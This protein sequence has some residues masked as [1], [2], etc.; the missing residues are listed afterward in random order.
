MTDAFLDFVGPGARL[1]ALQ[2]GRAEDAV[3]DAAAE[4][5]NAAAEVAKAQAWASSLGI[6]DPAT[7]T[8]KSARGYAID[9]QAIL[10]EIEEGSDPLVAAQV[11]AAAVSAAVALVAAGP[12]YASTA[13][14]LAATDEGDAFAVFDGI[15]TVT[16]YRHDAGPVATALRSFPFDLV[17]RL[18]DQEQ[19]IASI[20]SPTVAALRLGR[21]STAGNADVQAKV[22]SFQQ[23]IVHSPSVSERWRGVVRANGLHFH[24]PYDAT[25]VLVH[26]PDTGE[27]WQTNFGLDLSGT[28]KWR[29]A[30][31]A[32]NG[33]I[34]CVPYTSQSVLVIDPVAMTATLDVMGLPASALSGTAKWDGG[35]LANDGRIYCAPFQSTTLL[36]IDPANNTAQTFTA[37]QLGMGSTVLNGGTKYSGM[38]AVGGFVYATPFTAANVLRVNIATMVATQETYSLT[39]SDNNKWSRA[40]VV[41]T[42]IYCVPFTA[43]DILVI[44]TVASTGTR[45]AMGATLTGSNKWRAIVR[46]GR[47]LYGIPGDAGDF[48]QIDLAD[49]TGSTFGTAT[50]QTFNV[51]DVRTPT[52]TGTLIEQLKWSGAV[53]HKNIVYG[54]PCGLNQAAQDILIFDP[55]GNA[56]AGQ[57]YHTD[58]RAFLPTGVSGATKWFGGVAHPNGYVYSI[59]ATAQDFLIIRDVDAANDNPVAVRHA[60]GVTLDAVN[61][62]FQGGVLAGDM[63]IYSFPRSEETRVLKIDPYDLTASPYGTAILT[64]WGGARDRETGL[65]GQPLG[66][67][68]VDEQKWHSTVVG[69][70]GKIY[71]VPYNID[72][73]LI[74]DPKAPDADK[75]ELTNFG[76]NLSGID[77]WVGG[78]LHPNG[79][80]YCAP[81]SANDMLIIDTNPLSPTYNQAWRETFGLNFNTL[82]NA[83]QTTLKWSF[84]QIGAD[85]RIYMLPRTARN[86]LVFDPSDTSVHPMGRVTFE[87]FGLNMDPFSTLAGTG[88]TIASKAGPD[89]RIYAA[90]TGAPPAGTGN[91]LIIDTIRHTAT[92]EEFGLTTPLLTT[93]KVAGIVHTLTGRLICI[94]RSASFAIILKPKGVPALPPAAVLGPYLNK[95]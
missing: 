42:L 12:N 11:Q 39:L 9:A 84:P 78:C 77:K 85:S 69:M 57:A 64:D 27:A 5:V 92:Y 28:Q 48:L 21:E 62:K 51:Y 58:L 82:S 44:D 65:T 40:I 56:G 34:Y 72:K 94:P 22:T 2:A 30:V 88:Y 81:R 75:L 79:K 60:L 16:I 63:C 67:G 35:C 10:D 32:R 49:T 71:G 59:P 46:V 37:A 45:T 18:A 53:V 31:V 89:G 23:P 73:V 3:A 54:C 4:V 41:G 8:L 61:Q 6:P 50:R 80:I 26:N 7:P 24:I 70:D 14:G 90:S 33:L 13:A 52:T 19:Q 29:D 55:A 68:A 38:V 76:L 93:N 91:F 86:V 20:V 17:S 36:V 95:C 43:T 15:N 47:K 74:L 87:T 1:A 83:G 66:T 25:T